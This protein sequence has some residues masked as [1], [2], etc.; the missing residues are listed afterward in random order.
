MFV[1]SGPAQALQMPVVR[2]LACDEDMSG[3]EGDGIKKEPLVIEGLVSDFPHVNCPNVIRHDAQITIGRAHVCVVQ[4]ARDEC[5]V[6]FK[7]GILDGRPAFPQGVTAEISLDTGAET[8][9]F[10]HGIKRGNSY[11]AATFG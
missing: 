5:Q 4:F 10:N 9:R 2:V 6:S 11:H 8:P 3:V 1:G 7:N